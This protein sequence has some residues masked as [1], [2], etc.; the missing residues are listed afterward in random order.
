MISIFDYFDY[1]LFLRDYYK[2]Q[3]VKNPFFSYRY[4]GNRVAMD[5]SFLIKVLQGH[6]H[7]ANEKI[8]T[9]VEVC[10]L[11]EKEAVYFETLV[12]FCKAKTDKERKL[13]FEKLFTIGKI[14]SRKLDERQYRFFQNWY[15]SA[16]WSLL[17]FYPFEGNYSNLAAM[18]CPEISPRESR[19]SISLLESLGL[20]QKNSDGVYRALDR[21]L[22]TGR[23]WHSLAIS[24]YQKEM[25]LRAQESL[26]RDGKEERNISTVTMNISEKLLPEINGMIGT[27]R[28]TLIQMVNKMDDAATDRVYQLNVQLFPLSRRR[29]GGE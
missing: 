10:N 16:V 21:N 4:I 8:G 7:I 27:F 9:F 13:F 15:H 23:E 5:S 2:Q 25:M 6:L 28:E 19:Q 24:Q 20:I 17:N 3:K 11:K 18:L 12:Y 26:E 14:K 22:T 1:R 29:G